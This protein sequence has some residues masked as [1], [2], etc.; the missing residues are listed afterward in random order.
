MGL[1]S[2]ANNIRFKG[3]GR[4]Y[5]GAVGGSS[6]D[7][8][9]ELENLSFGINQPTEQIKS[10]RHASKAVILEATTEM[11]PALSFG[12]REMTEENLKALLL[13]T[14]I[15]TDNQA[16]GYTYQ[17]EIGTDINLADDLYVDTGYLDLFITKLTGEITGTIA[18]GDTL[19]GQTSSATGDIAYKGADYVELVNVSGTF[20]VGETCQKEENHHIVPT[21]VE[22]MQDV[23]ITDAAGTTR[24]AQTTDY[25][26]D[27]DSGFVRK[28]SSGGIIDTDKI[29]YD[30]EEVSR[31]SMY[32]GNA[33][34][35]QK[36][37]LVVTDKDDQGPRFKM[38]FHK[39]NFVLNGEIPLIGGEGASISTVNA[40][41]IWDSSQ[42]SGQEYFKL[43]MM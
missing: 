7:D 14:E 27:I 11:I 3:T 12:L 21:G 4:A 28:L 31:K 41:V 24:R 35:V 23:V 5:A 25:T 43:E 17:D 26:L 39:T 32:G 42:P 19:T 9:G 33:G 38:T 40:T 34:I 13:A 8:L 16:A 29:S 20:V 36:K 10:T 18:V 6:F 22:T 37:I 30:Y 2:S 1:A 15:N